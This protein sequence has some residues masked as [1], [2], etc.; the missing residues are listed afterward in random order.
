[1]WATPSVAKKIAARIFS[2]GSDP[3]TFPGY[4]RPPPTPNM[5]EDAAL[6]TLLTDV[7]VF[8]GACLDTGAQRTVIGN[9]QAKA[10][11]A[12][13]G[14]DAKLAT[15]KDLGRYRLGGGSYVTI[16]IVHIRVPIAEDF[17]LPLT[18]N[19]MDLNL[20]FLMGL[21]ILDVY[22]M[23]FNNMTNH[24]VCINEVVSVPLVRN[25]GHVYLDWGSSIL[26]TFPE[27]QRIHKN[28]YHAKAERLYALM[29]RA[30]D[31]HATPKTLRQ[32]ENVTEACDLCQRLAQEPSRF[33]VAM[34]DEDIC[35]NKRVM[36]D[37]MTLEQTSVLH[38][39]DRDT[40]F[41]AATFFHNKM[42]TKSVWEAF[43]CIWVS[44]YAGYP[45]QLHAD[46]GKNLQ[47][48]DWKQMMRNA[49]IK[50]LDSGIESHNS[51]VA[52]ERYHMMLR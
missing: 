46:K 5:E 22:R 26:Y 7:D 28:F 12:S 10:Y 29:R 42:D 30:K 8:H 14:R 27:L 21:D 44:A 33:R 20:P 1:M 37:I 13:I 50:P 45:E 40:L 17:F 43:L 24:L 4:K 2:R 48:Q 15:S 19:S 47:S 32:L 18:V 38:G 31:E 16:G 35:F 34:P 11:L 25:F 51:L 52:G 36:I 6:V 9:S 39:V 49:R 41:S 23:Y 3:S